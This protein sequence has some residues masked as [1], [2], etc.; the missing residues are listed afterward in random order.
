[1]RLRPNLAV[2]MTV[3]CTGCFG[4]CSVGSPS[5]PAGQFGPYSDS[6]RQL[7]LASGETFVVYR[8]KRWAFGDGSPPSLQLEY[9][10]PVPVSDT[11]TIRQVGE[12]IWPAFA[13]YVEAAGLRSAI[14]TATNLEKL[15]VPGAWAT[16]SHHF[17][18][19]ALRD[20]LGV[21]RFQDH[22]EV[23]PAVERGAI[24]RILEPSG[25]PVPIGASGRP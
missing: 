8:V 12:R 5:V 13:P 21:W 15:G 10:S 7:R 22:A 18:L 2:V 17:G 6:N 4:L 23:L 14:L 11:A 19:I 20:S 16:R 9:A 3:T 25:V 1:M 24:P